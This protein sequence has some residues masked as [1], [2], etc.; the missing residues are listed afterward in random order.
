MTDRCDTCGRFLGAGYRCDGCDEVTVHD[1]P[2]ETIG[3]LDGDTQVWVAIDTPICGVHLHPECRGIDEPQRP[4]AAATRFD[5]TEICS[6]CNGTWDNNVPDSG[7][8]R[9]GPQGVAADD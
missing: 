4:V 7:A 8:G 1:E 3:D 9:S 2:P 6:Y 5:D